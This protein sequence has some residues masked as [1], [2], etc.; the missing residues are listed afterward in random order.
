MDNVSL[1]EGYI[2]LHKILK[3]QAQES[4]EQNQQVSRIIRVWLSLYNFN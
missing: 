3:M 4:I 1:S 2:P